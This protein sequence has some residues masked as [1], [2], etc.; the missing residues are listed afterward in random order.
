[1]SSLPS[2]IFLS[3]S[4]APQKTV[5][6]WDAECG[7]CKYWITK[8]QMIVDEQNIDLRPYQ[9]VADDFPDLDK[10]LFKKAVRLVTPDG[11]VYSGASAAFK[12]LELGGATNLPMSWY[13]LNP[14]F[15]ELTEWLYQK[16]ADNRPFLYDI[17]HFFLGENPKKIYPSLW[18]WAGVG[19][20]IGG[21]LVLKLSGKK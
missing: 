15:A 17:S 3:T 18:V 11:T 7:F 4:H 6:I 21:S 8:W 1:M 20:L 13:E 14:T 2:Q 12:S 16:V 9:E 19:A 10:G 5:L